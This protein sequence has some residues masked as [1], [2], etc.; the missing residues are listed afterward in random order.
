MSAVHGTVRRFAVTRRGHREWR[1]DPAA[2]LA[3]T[4]G[5]LLV[6]SIA[7]A[8]W[9]WSVSAV[10]ISRL[11]DYG[12]PPALPLRW[13]LAL[14]LLLGG[15]VAA[16]RAEAPRPMV[17]GL[18]AVGIVFVLYGTVPLLTKVPQYTWTYK[19]IGVTRFFEVHGH[20]DPS[21]D[22]YNH[23]P[24]FF[25]LAALVSR[26]VGMPNPAAYAAWAEVVFAGLGAL[27]VAA[28]AR[29][30][31]GSPR[32]AGTAA[33]LFILGN[34]IGQSYFAPQA[35]AFTLT[36]AL[37]VI[38]LE[39]RGHA[40]GRIAAFV[41]RCG[42]RITKR[43]QLPDPA[44]PSTRLRKPSIV[45]ILLIDAILIP[46]HQLTPYMALLSVGALMALG[47]VR[48]RWVLAVMTL[49]T[50]AYLAINAKYLQDNYQLFTGLNPL[51]NL[52]H[53]TGGYGSEPLP[54]VH[55]AGHAGLVLTSLIWGGAAVATW[56]LARRGLA[57]RA[58][59]LV[60]LAVAPYAIFFGQNY[61]GE[62]V[63]RVTLFTT[64]WCSI[65]IAWAL[66]LLPRP[67]LR[68]ALTGG[69]LGI[70]AILFVLAFLGQATINIIHKGEAQASDYLYAHARA[71]SVIMPIAPNFPTRYGPRYSVFV[72]GVGDRPNLVSL[73]QFRHRPLGPRTIPGIIRETKKYSPHAYVVFSTAMETYARIFRLT[74]PGAIHDLELAVARSPRFR[75]WY[76]NKDA[77]IYELV[78]PRRGVPRRG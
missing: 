20:T 30:A 63:Y 42:E 19:H 8:L 21:L 1:I 49:L 36:M 59:P 44:S 47:M 29:V 58:L 69:T 25:A 18:Y 37:L 16:L 10:D 9:V 26:V 13:Y 40:D 33:F 64:P 51:G 70:M 5:A 56:S 27:M 75:L 39:H 45:W 48:P 43:P 41:L 2:V 52:Q 71:D 6:V 15:A 67:R 77:R 65:L 31:V 17:L 57:A 34:W 54:G 4:G 53:S 22:I 24:G 11:D 12:L 50:L 14:A 7:M 74:P 78:H 35:L 55:F 62:A 66:S 76:G 46:T 32:V 73:P 72:A 23:W 28:A 61:E 3:S 38:V 60:A 68:L